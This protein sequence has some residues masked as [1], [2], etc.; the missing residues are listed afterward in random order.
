MSDEPVQKVTFFI[1]TLGGGGTERVTAVLANEFSSHG[2]DVH[3]VLRGKSDKEYPTPDGIQKHYVDSEGRENRYLLLWRRLR[4]TRAIFTQIGDGPVIS[5]AFPPADISVVYGL[6]FSG[7]RMILSE[8]NNPQ[9]VPRALWKRA[10]RILCYCMADAVVFQTQNARNYFPKMIR[11][12]G[13][14]IPNPLMP[15]LPVRHEG[16]RRKE[17]VNFCRFATEKNLRLLI[18]AFALVA[19]KHTDF[20][21]VLYGH[22]PQEEALKEYAKQQ[23]V[24]GKVHFRGFSKDIHRAVVDSMMFVS[25]SDYEGLSNSMLEALAIGLPV[26]CTD[27]PAGG[28]RAFI[29]SDE[30]GLL[31]PPCDVAA[32]SEAMNALIENESLREKLSQNAVKIREV[33]QAEKIF[34]QWLALM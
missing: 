11:E 16:E 20:S 1:D 12:K 23:A 29:R 27:C 13:I 7:R 15:D 8:R 10:V 22:G 25:S 28:G 21:L 5:L 34:F 6:L 4:K 19:E 26:I 2:F 3:I 18:D 14:I 32:L 17:V 31:V 30:N 24:A 33:L 9:N